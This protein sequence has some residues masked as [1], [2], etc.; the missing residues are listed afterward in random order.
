V[1][2]EVNKASELNATKEAYEEKEKVETTAA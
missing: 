1:V 2:N